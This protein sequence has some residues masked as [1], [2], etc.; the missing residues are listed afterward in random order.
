M[1]APIDKSRAPSI[2]RGVPLSE[3]PG[4]GSLTLPGFLREVTTRHATREALVMHRA[5]EAVRWSYADL[6]ER[7]VEVARALIAIGV[8]KHTHVGILMTNRLEWMSATFGAWLAGATAVQL[9][10]FSTLAELDYLLSV[11][12]VSVLMFEGTVLKKNF[13]SMLTELEPALDSSEPGTLQSLKYPFLHHLAVVDAAAGGAI[14]RWE[15]FLSR[16]ARIRSA[17]VEAMVDTVKP[18]DTAGLFFSSGSTARPKGILNSHRGIAIQF[19]RFARHSALREDARAWTPNG[20][21]WS[22]NC[23]TVMGAT[24]ACGGSIVLQSI[25][26]PSEALELMQT[27]RVNFPMVWP[28]QARLLEEAPNWQ[29]VDLSAMTY[30]DPASPMASH[31]SIRLKGWHDPR[32]SYGS[33]E[34]FTISTGYPNDIDPSIA[35]DSHGVALPGNTIKIVDPISGETVSVG[36]HGEI[37]VKGPTLMQGY[38]G[39]PLEETL[40]A[41]G[42]YPTGDGGYLDEAGRLYFQGRLTSVIKT[43]GANVSPLEVDHVLETFPGVR[44]VCTVGVPHDLLGEIVVACIVPLEGISLDSAGIVAFARQRLASY[45]V[46]RRVLFLKEN[47]IELTGTSKIKPKELRKLAAQRLQELPAGN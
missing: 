23:A 45:K 37:A 3:E 11:S 35:R 41:E 15:T 17:L 14:E 19:W 36:D 8:G 18:T 42:F 44:A 5:G 33:T 39:V 40:D 32:A 12:C 10:T 22:G 31:P 34:T 28:H 21:F 20:F 16:G 1:S 13:V 2:S 38:L 6:W 25:F 24:L 30:L 9:S 7:S 27:E 29:E 43:G 26:I 47:E 46:P 4:L